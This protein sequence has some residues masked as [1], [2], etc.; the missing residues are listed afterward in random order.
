MQ[1]ILTNDIATRKFDNEILFV[2]SLGDSYCHKI[3]QQV[4]LETDIHENGKFWANIEKSYYMPEVRVPFQVC[5]VFIFYDIGRQFFFLNF[6]KLLQITE[7][8]IRCHKN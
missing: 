3:P 4:A 2:P 1:I 8:G 5:G 7:E 6:M